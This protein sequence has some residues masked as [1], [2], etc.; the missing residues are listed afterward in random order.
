MSDVRNFNLKLRMPVLIGHAIG[1]NEAARYWDYLSVL[2]PH[3]KDTLGTYT[4]NTV[5]S[6]YSHWKACSL[7]EGKGLSV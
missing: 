6:S 7:K 1:R 2:V 4:A 3:A 5:G